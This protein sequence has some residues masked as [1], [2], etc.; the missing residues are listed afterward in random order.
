[1]IEESKRNPQDAVPEKHVIATPPRQDHSLLGLWMSLQRRM[2]NVFMH[3]THQIAV[4]K[5]VGVG[6]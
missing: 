3:P 6:D 4:V 1:M 5:I 2:I